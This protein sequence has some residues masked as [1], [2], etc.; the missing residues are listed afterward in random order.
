MAERGANFFLF[1]A[2]KIIKRTQLVLFE[3]TTLFIIYFPTHM[4]KT[5]VVNSQR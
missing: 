1:Y 5:Q 2:N 4:I 3:T